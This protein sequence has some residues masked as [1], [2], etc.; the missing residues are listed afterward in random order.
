N[1][2]L[3]QLKISGEIGGKSC[4]SGILQVSAIYQ[5]GQVIYIG[6]THNELG[7]SVSIQV[8]DEQGRTGMPGF[9]VVGGL[10]I[11][12]A[13][14][15]QFNFIKR[16][17]FPE[18]SPVIGLHYKMQAVGNAVKFHTEVFV[19]FHTSPQNVEGDDVNVSVSVNIGNSRNISETNE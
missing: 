12:G 8:V 4:K 9:S 11:V 13:I 16:K 6:V 19:P 17:P 3:G 18:F 14:T 2:R 1:Y 10:L 5:H 15:V 7:Q